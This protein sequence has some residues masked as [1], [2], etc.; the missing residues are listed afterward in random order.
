MSPSLIDRFPH[1]LSGGQQQRVNIAR[2][3][4][5]QPS[6]LILDEPTSS[7]DVSV[8]ADILTLLA[9]LRSELELT[10]VLISHDL[11]TI[12]NV[13]ESAV[14]MYSGR[15][16]ES[17]ATARVLS[18]PA[19]PYTELLLDCELSLDPEV[20]RRQPAT[21]DLSGRELAPDAC[22]FA[23]RCAF[24]TDVCSARRPE[25]AH[26]GEAHGVACVHPRVQVETSSTA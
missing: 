11:A 19:H 3:L 20:E 14:V 5:T 17:G 13:C 21:S 16:V 24:F 1:Q 25:W 12:R 9:R 8:R 10:Y 26:V 18:N 7:L 2:A 6:V 22:V 4:A 23:P 15:I